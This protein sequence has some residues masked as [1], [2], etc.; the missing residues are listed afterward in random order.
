[1]AWRMW[2]LVKPWLPLL[3]YGATSLGFLLAVAL[4]KT[5]VFT[6]LDHLSQ[7]L[8]TDGW[9]GYFV[10]Y[11]LIF[12]T[13]I[14]P[15]PLYSTLIVLSGYTFGAL[16]GLVVSYTAALTGALAVFIVSRF[17]FKD[18]I[19]RWF[20]QFV[21]LKRVVRAIEKRPK[22]LFLIR[23]A[24][25]PYNVM[26]CL[27]AASPTLTLRTYAL[28]T[29]LSL[30]KLIIHTTVG[31]TIHSFSRHYLKTPSSP[32]TGD[33]PPT[34]GSSDAPPADQDEEKSPL[35]TIS[36]IVGVVLCVSIFLYLSYV[37]RK[38]VDDELGDEEDEL[39]SG[40]H[41]R[42]AD[43]EERVG[44]MDDAARQEEGE[45]VLMSESPFR[46]SLQQQRA[47]SPVVR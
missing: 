24:P 34:D 19:S 2:R 30:F 38:A 45:T 26:N 44:L 6:G 46:P 11:S 47:S 35:G 29:A 28:C 31:S 9:A 7:F 43:S 1:M 32:S 18:S 3:A 37:A 40:A 33:G 4:W 12:I 27:L 13:T 39:E 36:T 5:Q 41:P 23:V 15:V 22:L 42:G 17:F 20:S 14:P 16:R 10:L 25:Y 8:Q 21:Y